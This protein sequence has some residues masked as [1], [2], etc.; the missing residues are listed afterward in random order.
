MIDGSFFAPYK[1]FLTCYVLPVRFAS[2]MCRES[3]CHGP[4]ADFELT[5]H[6]DRVGDFACN[7]PFEAEIGREGF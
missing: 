4:W 5:S 7:S 6:R 1:S 3:G 2:M